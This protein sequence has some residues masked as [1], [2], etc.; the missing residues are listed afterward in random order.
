MALPKELIKLF[1]D[2][3][4]GI[5]TY[6]SIVNLLP[7]APTKKETKEILALAKE[8]NIRLMTAAEVAKLKNLEDVV[9][10]EEER[11]RKK[12]ELAEEIL[13]EFNQSA[14]IIG[15]AKDGDKVVMNSYYGTKRVIEL[16]KGELLPRI[17]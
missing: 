17:C 12:E 5:V 11:E 2:N 10:N 1:K 16:P 13:K 4:N 7:K 6:E 15:E 3:R 8:N 14:S 9:K